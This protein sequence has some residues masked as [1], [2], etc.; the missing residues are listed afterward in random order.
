MLCSHFRFVFV[1]FF[2]RKCFTVSGFVLLFCGFCLGR[3]V[4]VLA[5]VFLFLC[6]AFF[7]FFVFAVVTQF[8]E[9][10]Y[11]CIVVLTNSENL[12]SPT[13]YIFLKFVS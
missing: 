13:A 11:C 9:K 10:N 5:C 6:L 3:R 7:K 4:S 8:L 1:C 12:Y 2:F